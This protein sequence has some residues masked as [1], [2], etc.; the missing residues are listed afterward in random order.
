MSTISQF[1]APDHHR[2]DSLFALAE[3]SAA[4]GEWEKTA[5]NFASFR[6]ALAH[7]FAMEEQVMF[8]AFEE[9]TGMTAG[10]TQVMRMEHQQMRE[11]LGQMAEAAQKRDKEEFLGLSDTLLLIMQQHNVKEEQMLYRMA[12]QAL[13]G[14]T[15][16]LVRRMR[17]IA[18]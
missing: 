6:K 12:D 1:L 4:S 17:E 5:D 2:C 15:D 18:E 10:P 11:L 9:H 8:P 7:H 14:A 16:D 13:A 3:E